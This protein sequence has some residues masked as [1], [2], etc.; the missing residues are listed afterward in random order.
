M[1]SYCTKKFIRVQNAPVILAVK[2][3]YRLLQMPALV[4]YVCGQ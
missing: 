1:M 3:I 4:T 2:F